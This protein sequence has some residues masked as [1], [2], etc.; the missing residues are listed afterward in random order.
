MED[1]WNLINIFPLI[2]LTQSVIFSMLYP[3]TEDH[4]FRGLNPTS[5]R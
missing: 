5:T 2:A 4:Q 3:E 1:Y